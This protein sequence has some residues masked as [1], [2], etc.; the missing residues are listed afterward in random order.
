MLVIIIALG[1]IIGIL[2]G[3]FRIIL[4]WTLPLA[5]VQRFDYAVHRTMIFLL[6]LVI[7]AL[8]GLI[9]FGMTL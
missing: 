6:K 7:V 5:A 1:V 2:Y 8:A 4:G 3:A 9:I